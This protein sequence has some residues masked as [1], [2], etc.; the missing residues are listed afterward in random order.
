MCRTFDKSLSLL[1]AS[2]FRFGNIKTVKLQG[3]MGVENAISRVI[4][5]MR[6]VAQNESVARSMGLEVSL[7]WRSLRTSGYFVTNTQWAI[8]ADVDKT[9]K[10]LMEKADM[11]YDYFGIHIDENGH[12]I[13]I[14][15]PIEGFFVSMRLTSVL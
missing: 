8:N 3:L 10:K 4:A 13:E 5:G 14:P 6:T 1:Q 11:L 15:V 12:L 7:I 2:L 9:F